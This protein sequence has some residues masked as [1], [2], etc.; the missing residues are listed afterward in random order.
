MPTLAPDPPPS[1]KKPPP[2]GHTAIGSKFAMRR[3]DRVN[4]P[5]CEIQMPGPVGVGATFARPLTGRISKCRAKGTYG[6]N[7]PYI[8]EY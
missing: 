4:S 7:L 1:G 3:M 5:V 8:I 6:I 2:T